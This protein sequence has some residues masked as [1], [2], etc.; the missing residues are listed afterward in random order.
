MTANSGFGIGFAKAPEAVTIGLSGTE[1][2]LTVSAIRMAGIAAGRP[3][4]RVAL[5]IRRT[6][7]VAPRQARP[8]AAG[9]PSCRRASLASRLLRR[10]GPSTRMRPS[11]NPNRLSVNPA[12]AGHRICF[13]G[14]PVC[15]IQKSRGAVIA[16]RLFYFSEYWFR[17]WRWLPVRR[18]LLLRA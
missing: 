15:R 18:Q 3:D 6:G 10:P 12:R 1:R 4:Q 16:P 13:N 5:R 11:P 9:F 14:Q 2:E 17:L 8:R 7:R